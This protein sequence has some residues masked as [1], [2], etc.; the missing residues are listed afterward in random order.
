MFD[1]PQFF[2]RFVAA[3]A[4]FPNP[5]SGTSFDLRKHLRRTRK[6]FIFRVATSELAK[7]LFHGDLVEFR[8]VLD[9]EHHLAT[10]HVTLNRIGLHPR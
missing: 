2:A 8:L 3:A 5:K 1:S 10:A 9:R 6:D 4:P 7:R